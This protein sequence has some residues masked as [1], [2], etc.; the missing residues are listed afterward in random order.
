MEKW[1]L[2]KPVAVL[3]KAIAELERLKYELN[4]PRFEA[5]YSG[6]NSQEFWNAVDPLLGFDET[7]HEKLKD[8]Q[9]LEGECLSILNSTK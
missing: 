4:K 7:L 5:H 9:D 1:D 8:L 3:D 2:S 6:P